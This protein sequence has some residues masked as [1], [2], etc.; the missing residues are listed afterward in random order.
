M[1]WWNSVIKAVHTHWPSYAGRDETVSE[2]IKISL[3]GYVCVLLYMFN[4][5]ML[6]EKNTS[7]V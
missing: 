7:I 5:N 3:K 1:T 2:T 4:A 6:K